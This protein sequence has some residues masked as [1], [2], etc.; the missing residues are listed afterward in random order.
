[1]RLSSF[2]SFP[3]LAADDR[4]VCTSR[5]MAR[6]EMRRQCVAARLARLPSPS[7]SSPLAPTLA[8]TRAPAAPRLGPCLVPSRS[9]A[10]SLSRS[11]PRARSVGVRAGARAGARESRRALG[12]CARADPRRLRVA[13]R[14]P[15]LRRGR[16]SRPRT[17]AAR[18]RPAPAHAR[19]E[20]RREVRRDT[21]ALDRPPR[22]RTSARART[23]PNSTRLQRRITYAF[24][25]SRPL[26]RSLALLC[27]LSAPPCGWP[28][29]GRFLYARRATAARA[30]GDTPQPSHAAQQPS[31]AQGCG[32]ADGSWERCW[33]GP[34]ARGRGHG[35]GE[36]RA[37]AVCLAL[38]CCWRC[39]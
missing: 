33:L 5:V 10:L 12:R 16:A 3:N 13:R 1:M 6:F 4:A 17:H 14:R 26:L 20:R 9:L 15:V 31:R 37:R 39:W 2:S 29:G 28:G 34:S 30:R 25:L 19:A 24:T 22:G 8:L 38:L 23:R 21:H 7:R 18:T 32:E 35:K 27:R 11:P 36:G